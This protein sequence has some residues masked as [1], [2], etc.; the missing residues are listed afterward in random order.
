MFIFSGY[1]YLIIIVLQVICIIHCIRKGN[2]N[3]WIWFIIFLPVIGS[4]V[5]LFSEIFTDREI[6]Q[7]QSGVGAVFNPTGKIKK[8]EKDLQF[9]DTFNNRVALADAYLAAGQNEKAIG[10][11]ESSLQGNF[12]ENEYVLTK[13]II[14]YFEVKRYKD[15]LPIAK[16]IYRLPQFN[17]SHAHVLYAVAL[18]HS[19][20]ADLAEKEFAG[21]KSR[22][23]NF[24][25]RYQ[26]GAF[27]VRN[28][29]MQEARILLNEMLQ[30]QSQLST[31]E[32]RYNRT[33]LNLAK[34]ELSKIKDKTPVS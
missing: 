32:K 13:L 1:F 23:S 34:E 28:E 8:L 30:E 29:R 16:K 22:F 24:E 7:V 11:Y 3:Y 21:M 26:Y 27:L 6:K 5:Y 33:W 14:A 25:A 10:L 12:T 20:H 15:I 31:R 17:K 4:L 19:G 2:S 18:D 9:S